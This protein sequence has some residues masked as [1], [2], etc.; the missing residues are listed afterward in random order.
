MRQALSETRL[1]MQ[2]SLVQAAPL[3]KVFRVGR[4][5]IDV[6]CRGVR[7]RG[8]LG[9]SPLPGALPRVVLLLPPPPP[10]LLRSATLE[11]ER[12]RERKSVRAA[13]SGVACFYKVTP[14]APSTCD[15]E[16]KHPSCTRPQT[17]VESLS[18]YQHLT[19]PFMSMS[20]E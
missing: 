11:S 19:L 6:V 20:L 9:R 4:L 13:A 5:L 16:E 1:F 8:R 3:L 2:E 12:V 17:A 10:G 15:C 18:A 7:H 14:T